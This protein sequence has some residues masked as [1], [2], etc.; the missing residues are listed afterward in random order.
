LVQ[1]PQSQVNERGG[2]AE[3]GILPPIMGAPSSKQVLY[4]NLG[5]RSLPWE[6]SGWKPESLSWKTACYI[7]AGLSG[8]QIDLDGEDIEQFLSTLCTNSFKRFDIGSMKHAV[9][10][11]DA[12]LVASHAI[13]QR[14][15]RQN[16]RLFAAGYPWLEFQA[17]R[18]PLRVNVRR[19]PAF[20]FQVAGPTSIFTLEK[21]TG[22][23]LRDIEFL[24]FRTA[25]IGGY[26]VEIGRIGM[27][28][29]LA[30]EVRGPMDQGPH[31]F[32]EICRAGAEFGIERLG[33]KTYFVNHVEGGFPQTG[34]TFF[35][36]AVA[37]PDFNTF[38]GRPQP[39]LT[40]SAS[41]QDLAARFRNPLELGW[42][43]AVKFDHNFIGRDALERL[44]E[45]SH[46]VSVTLR[47]SASD[48]KEINGSLLEP[49]PE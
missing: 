14:N 29:N 47:W 12:G 36:A 5:E 11:T 27:S 1:A 38:S 21:A 20:L 40:G 23:S 31:V 39:R 15:G 44:K 30:Y 37:D 24:R 9:M 8:Y 41:P 6:Y 16:Y 33:F 13:L 22:E 34:W 43:R 3:S 46:R 49:D 18:S 25:R 2:V 17:S 45:S 35:S 48:V 42:G 28:G 7:H 19:T 10:C 32:D 26:S 4:L